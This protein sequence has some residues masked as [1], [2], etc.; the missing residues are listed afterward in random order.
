MIFKL[1]LLRCPVVVVFVVAVDAVVVAIVAAAVGLL[2]MLL[3]V[4][5]GDSDKSFVSDSNGCFT[6]TYFLQLFYNN[7]QFTNARQRTQHFDGFRLGLFSLVRVT[8]AGQWPQKI[9]NFQRH[10]LLNKPHYLKYTAES[11]KQ[12]DS[13]IFK[14]HGHTTFALAPISFSDIFK[15]YGHTTYALVRISCQ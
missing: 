15:R 2:C 7:W 12:F 14:K 13:D 1:L 5:I 4:C 11:T 10:M 9:R 8:A 6:V 3:L